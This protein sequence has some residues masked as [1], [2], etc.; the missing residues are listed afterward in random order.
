MLKDAVMHV[1]ELA[2]RGLEYLQV[3]RRSPER[4][5]NEAEEPERARF[6]LA[7][8]E[9]RPQA[10]KEAEA[11]DTGDDDLPSETRMN[12]KMWKRESRTS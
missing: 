12:M 7:A 4:R 10:T 6:D 2:V 8:S 5:G 9:T 1:A 3:N 11:Q